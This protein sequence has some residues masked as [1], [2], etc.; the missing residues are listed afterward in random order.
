M[1]LFFHENL[2]RRSRLVFLGGPGEFGCENFLLKL[3][4]GNQRVDCY[5]FD[6]TNSRELN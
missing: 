2:P 6:I 3:H 4:V 5:F 1:M